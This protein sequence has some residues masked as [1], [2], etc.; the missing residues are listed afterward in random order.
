[1]KAPTK[2]IY[3]IILLIVSL[4]SINKV[5]SQNQVI[6][7]IQ[8]PP[9][10]QLTLADFW[11]LY[12]NNTTGNNLSVFFNATLTEK[13][14][15]LIIKGVTSQYTLN[16]GFTKLNSNDFSSVN[17][18]YPNPEPRYEKSIN[19]TGSVPP[20]NYTLCISVLQ[21]GN[22]NELGQDCID[23][24]IES[25]SILTLVT[26]GDEETIQQ[27]APAFTWI[28]IKK[29][30]SSET[31]SIKIVEVNENQTPEAA[32][33]ENL[34][35]FE[36]SKILTNLFQYPVSARGFDRGKKYAWQIKVY[37]E[38][39]FLVESEVWIFQVVD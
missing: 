34:V 9:K 33:Q 16:T 10:N 27:S 14:A 29:P 36:K 28:Y 5:F 23:Q 31:F 1:M 30:G 6:V 25:T 15:G 39:T 13:S 8:Q 17:L 11:N 7:N 20:G 35:W 18:Y 4:L 37:D 32:I 3:T 2:I 24:Y 19:K 21:S 26:P 38:R 12:L 22:N